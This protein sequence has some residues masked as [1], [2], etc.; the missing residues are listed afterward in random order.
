MIGLFQR[1]VIHSPYTSVL[2]PTKADATAT[3]SYVS[4]IVGCK[5][6]DKQCMLKTSAMDFL[7]AGGKL[8]DDCISNLIEYYAYNT[9]TGLYLY[10]I[11]VTYL[12]YYIICFCSS[13]YSII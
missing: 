12:V 8:I 4:N 11:Y 7:N 10:D 6:F 5:L 1:A 2:F 9:D 13:K 3:S